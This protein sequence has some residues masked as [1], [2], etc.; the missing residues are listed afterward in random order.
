MRAFELL[1]LAVLSVVSVGGAVASSQNYQ[2]TIVG[3]DGG[4]G[5]G[6]TSADYTSEVSFGLTAGRSSAPAIYVNTVGFVAQFNSPPIGVDDL[7]SHGFDQPVDILIPSLLANDS[8]PDQVEEILALHTFN[9]RTEA[10]GSVLFVAPYLRYFP[11]AGF[12]GTD[13]FNYTL[14]DPEGDVGMATVEV[15]SIPAS[16]LTPNTLTMVKLADGNY[17]VRFQG[18][19]NATQFV[20]LTKTEIGAA[21]WDLLFAKENG[22][23]GLVEFMVNPRDGNQRFYEVQTF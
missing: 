12:R 14:V 5:S 17:L 10:G 8:D 15:V 3:I 19:A 9:L 6:A 16:N 7:R 4:G 2:L 23:D 22:G 20:V 18:A 21:T 1:F 11:P 13:H